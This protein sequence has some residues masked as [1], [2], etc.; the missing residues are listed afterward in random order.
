[1]I[2]DLYVRVSRVTGP[3]ASGGPSFASPA[4]GEPDRSMPAQ[5]ILFCGSEPVKTIHFTRGSELSMPKA[6]SSE[7]IMSVLKAFLCSGRLRTTMTTGVTD[8][9]E[10]GWCKKRTAGRDTASYESGGLA[11]VFILV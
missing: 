2:Q 7:S 8:L 6:F 5:K 1:M 3:G 9:D 4:A 10:G 11:I